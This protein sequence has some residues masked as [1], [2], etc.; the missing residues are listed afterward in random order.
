MFP[1]K[2]KEYC[3]RDVLPECRLQRFDSHRCLI[4][5]TTHEVRMKMTPT[6]PPW[7][8]IIMRLPCSVIWGNFAPHQRWQQGEYLNAA[9]IH[10]SLFPGNCSHSQQSNEM[11]LI[12]GRRLC[13]DSNQHILTKLIWP[14]ADV[15]YIV[16][17]GM[18]CFCE[19][20]KH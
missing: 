9:S 20:Y 19:R 16:G 3:N 1:S 2:I 11:A 10:K 15:A 6:S 8:Q 13:N 18:L 17:S 7:R 12:Y 14:P 4:A 5:A